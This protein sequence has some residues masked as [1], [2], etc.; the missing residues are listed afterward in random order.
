MLWHLSTSFHNTT[1]HT[2]V[3]CFDSVM[4]HGFKGFRQAKPASLRHIMHWHVWCSAVIHTRQTRRHSVAPSYGVYAHYGRRV[5]VVVTAYFFACVYHL[6]SCLHIG[7]SAGNK[8][9]SQLPYTPVSY[10]K[11][12]A[13]YS[14]RRCASPRRSKE[15]PSSDGWRWTSYRHSARV[16][17]LHLAAYLAVQR[18]R[19]RS[20]VFLSHTHWACGWGSRQTREHCVLGYT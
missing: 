5:Q 4:L 7:H 17:S 8:R 6:W 2:Y 3:L 18:D 10:H 12:S 15:T 14:Q 19:T 11:I 20:L 13:V 16:H 1:Q 9:V